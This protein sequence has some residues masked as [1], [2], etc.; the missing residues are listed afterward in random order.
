[1]L[2]VD[3]SQT[4]TEVTVTSPTTL[5]WYRGI[6]LAPGTYQFQGDLTPKIKTVLGRR[7]VAAGVVLVKVVK[8]GDAVV[9]VHAV[10]EPA[11]APE[12]PVDE[13]PVS[14]SEP[15]VIEEEDVEEKPVVKADK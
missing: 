8:P 9:T 7:Q 6:K 12:K 14:D 10:A 4:Y 11:P 15:V 3:L 1:M 2:P 13:T 5:D